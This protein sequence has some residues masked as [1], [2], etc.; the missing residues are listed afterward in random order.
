MHGAC[1]LNSSRAPLG[2]G[3][4]SGVSQRAELRHIFCVLPQELLQCFCIDPNRIGDA[5]VGQRAPL[6]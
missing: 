4:N 3:L 6:A 1:P 5:D 2:A